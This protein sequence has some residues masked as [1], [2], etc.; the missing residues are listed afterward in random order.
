[1]QTLKT[2]LLNQ[3]IGAIIIALLFTRAISLTL[4]LIAYPIK[5]LLIDFFLQTNIRESFA[6]MKMPPAPPT[7]FPLVISILLAFGSGY[8]LATWLYG[9]VDQPAA[10]SLEEEV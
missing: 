2:I 10:E 3:Y 4:E 7:L 6:N 8:L 9:T 5:A 1:M